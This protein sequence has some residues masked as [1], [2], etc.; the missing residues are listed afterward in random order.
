MLSMALL[1]EPLSRYSVSIQ[2]M[3]Q[4]LLIRFGG[5][6]YAV[7]VC[8]DIFPR[9][10][11]S[12]CSCLTKAPPPSM[13]KERNGETGTGGG[14][15]WRGAVKAVSCRSLCYIPLSCCVQAQMLAFALSLYQSSC[16]C[17]HA[18][19]KHLQSWSTTVK[20]ALAECALMSGLR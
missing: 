1:D 8:C 9:F 10:V 16:V 17:D 4:W 12:L 6:Y 15:S 7:F 13:E 3:N 5:G 20:Y 11:R 18:T 19:A 2:S 14:G